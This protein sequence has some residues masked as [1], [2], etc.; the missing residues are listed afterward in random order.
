M[1]KTVV[2]VDIGAHSI[3]AVE[4]SNY[5][6]AKPAVVRMAEQPLPDNAIRRGEEIGRAHV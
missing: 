4:V 3:R 6:T 1:G 5:A 2:G